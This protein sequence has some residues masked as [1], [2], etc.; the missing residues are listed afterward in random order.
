MPKTM[1]LSEELLPVQPG[2]RFSG[3]NGQEMEYYGQRHVH[4][5]PIEFWEDEFGYPFRGQA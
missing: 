1:L 3:P 2:V 5:V 4:F